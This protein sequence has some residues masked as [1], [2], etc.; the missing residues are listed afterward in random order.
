ML[1]IYTTYYED[2]PFIRI[3]DKEVYPQTKSVLGSNYCDIGLE[4]DDRTGRVV[5]MAALDNLGK[6]AAGAALQ[7]LN[8]MFS[9]DETD[10]LLSPGLMP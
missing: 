2:E 5:A 8:L 4:V 7:N 9:Y 6:G 10:G 1:H 3:L